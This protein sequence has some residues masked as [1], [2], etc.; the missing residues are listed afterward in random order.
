MKQ[1]YS[2][3]LLLIL[4]ICANAQGVWN[5]GWSPYGGV[6]NVS[7]NP[8]IADSRHYLDI[9][10]VSLS[11]QSSYTNLDFENFAIE[12][13]NVGKRFF[14]NAKAD[15]K[16]FLLNESAQLQLPS[17][18]IAPGRKKR[19]NWACAFSS[20]HNSYSHFSGNQVSSFLN[21]AFSD[22]S[23]N[24]TDS[25]GNLSLALQNATWIENDATFSMVAMN[26]GKHLLKWGINLATAQGNNWR[27]ATI[28]T[29]SYSKN[30]TSDSIL[31]FANGVQQ[32]GGLV[33]SEMYYFNTSSHRPITFSGDVGFSYEYRKE[34]DGAE[35]AMDGEIWRD[36]E[37]AR[38]TVALG[39]TYA[40]KR[41]LLYNKL[42]TS[43]ASPGS[44]LTPTE[45]ANDEGEL[46]FESLVR[47][48]SGDES[49]RDVTIIIPAR[50]TGFIDFNFR[51]GLGA[52]VTGN[53]FLN[54]EPTAKSDAVFR[55][56]DVTF[57]LKYEEP[58]IGVYLPVSFK[59]WSASNNDFMTPADVITVG[60]AFRFEVFYIGIN[61][62][63][64]EAAKQSYNLNF[65][66]KIPMRYKRPDDDDND[67]ASNTYDKCPTDPG[68][69]TAFGCP[70]T[71]L[72]SIPNSIDDCVEWPGLK[73][74]KGCPDSDLDSIPD[75]W[76]DC[77]S[78]SGL[79]KFFGCPDHDLDNIP[80][81]LDLCDTLYAPLEADGCPDID[82]DGVY[83]PYD[84][85]D[86]I[87]GVEAT[88]GCPDT[89]KDGVADKDD[90]C[91]DVKG[92][93]DR[94]DFQ[95]CP[96]SDDDG[97]HDGMD[98][99]I[100]VKGNPHYK[101]CPIP[102][103]DND[104]V[105]DNEDLCPFEKGDPN[106]NGCLPQFQNQKR[107]YVIYFLDSLVLMEEED[108]EM[109]NIELVKMMDKY[110]NYRLLIRT[111]PDSLNDSGMETSSATLRGAV[112]KQMIADSGVEEERI[113]VEVIYQPMVSGRIT[114]LPHQKKFIG[115]EIYVVVGEI[116][117]IMKNE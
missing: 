53:Y 15:D 106:F 21:D 89:D 66:L 9:N 86:T 116:K 14:D 96:D 107:Q 109:L 110:S 70:D 57:C 24:A 35:Y 77:D 90:L 25:A 40:H 48:M 46:G 56:A 17:V 111:F 29:L 44:L 60:G 76:D 103:S 102:D 41:T 113:S 75:N 73:I 47:Q 11:Y 68:A 72:D 74:Y 104:K 115:A 92:Y 83:D 87:P 13:K 37:R 101:G 117:T 32:V 91:K 6:N 12:M 43:E 45:K 78:L 98:D 93:P 88:K 108:E 51:K 10:L 79:A 31:F 63:V 112:L 85:C 105:P 19:N 5:A 7:I 94:P 99:C 22:G 50:I 36:Y 55:P 39:V 52:N 61:V 114:R 62:G 82:D 38:H 54:E 34:G 42:P 64:G 65:G 3:V 18:L 58:K 30:V 33:Q 97:M 84:E 26:T 1:F 27:Q 28:D 16:P 8:A 2:V 95:G 81:P 71:D 23:F 59:Q 100:N 80:F 69:L 20:Y 49:S 67:L 4:A